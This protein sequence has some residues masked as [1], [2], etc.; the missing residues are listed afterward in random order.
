M[1]AGGGGGLC[2]GAAAGAGW[3]WRLRR[4]PNETPI[5]V[6]PWAAAPRHKFQPQTHDCRTVWDPRWP[7]ALDCH[8]PSSASLFLNSIVEL[9]NVRAPAST[10]PIATSVSVHRA[11]RGKLL[12]KTCRRWR[13]FAQAPWCVQDMDS[14]MRSQSLGG[15]RAVRNGH[16]KR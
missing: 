3:R 7:H 2:A 4:W 6:E 12:L 14:L 5:D 1:K 13:G 9:K 16:R 10:T 11:T 15:R 8:N